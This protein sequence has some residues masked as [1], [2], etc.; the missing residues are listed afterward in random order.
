MNYS[1]GL[2]IHFW[3]QG[4][5]Y[6]AAFFVTALIARNQTSWTEKMKQKKIFYLKVLQLL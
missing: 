3:H 2:L 5:L 6:P 4:Q 1:F